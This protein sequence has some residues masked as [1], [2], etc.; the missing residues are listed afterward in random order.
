[1]RVLRS[2]RKSLAPVAL[3]TFAIAA[4]ASCGGGGTST[5]RSA[6][7][8]GGGSDATADGTSSAPPGDGS[9]PQ[10]SFS[11]DSGA[12]DANDSS[13]SADSNGDGPGSQPG[14]AGEDDSATALDA[15]GDS[16]SGAADGSPS[17]DAQNGAD[18]EAGLCSVDG[19]ACSLDG[20][21]GL[22]GAGACGSCSDPSSDSVCSGAYGDGG[23]GGY[24]CT[25]GSCVPGNCHTDADCNGGICGFVTA[26]FCAGCTADS[27]CQSD[28]TYGPSTIC[29][30]SSKKCVTSAC[31]TVAAA[32]SNAGDICCPGVSGNACVPGN[33]CSDAQCSG[34]T[35]VCNTSTNACAV[36]DAV[37]AGATYVIVDPVNGKDIASNGSGTVGSG[38]VEDG[39]CA[40]KTITFALGHLP[41]GPDGGASVVD[42]VRVLPTG[43]VATGE[44]FPITVPAGMTIEGVGGP[45][46]VNETATGDGTFTGVAF[47]LS[48]AGSTLSNLIIDGATTGVRGVR[49]TTGSTLTTNLVNVEVR[50]FTAAGIRVELSGKLTI[51]S[52]TSAHN[53]GSAGTEPCGLR[54][55]GQAQVTITGGAVPIQFNQNTQN[56]I[57]VDGAGSV[58]ITGTPSGTTGSVVANANLVDGIDIHQTVATAS[59]ITGLVAMGNAED[60]ARFYGPSSVQVR[61]SIFL[62][63][64]NNGVN[65][66]PEGAGANENDVAAI[67]LGTA[68]SAGGNTFQS[69]T[70]PNAFAGICL[71]I[72]T[73]A[74]QTLQAQGNIWGAGDGGAL[75]C[76]AAGTLTE[77]TGKGCSGG[78]DIGGS[79]LSATV[80]AT[81]NGVDVASCS[82]GGNTTCK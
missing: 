39:A 6:S 35:P 20:G 61:G 49:A 24:I 58:T 60:G 68:V 40:F 8:D 51:N 33:C 19:T 42:D 54:V 28:V 27:Q 81:S 31:T 14:E 43:P 45:V 15:G 32:C 13:S 9:A 7:E 66:L 76:G 80:T 77:N 59:T 67:D 47:T 71:N 52:G 74:S 2:F 26:Q 5:T 30:T 46:T 48:A 53:N 3:A 11:Q 4:V 69:A 22:C 34:T 78:V 21:N 29:D 65:V 38:A 44:D 37:G 82:C 12:G 57:L 79:G 1:M 55:T 50:N 73:G 41:A 10:D 18:S 16:E 75:N 56:G 72:G 64:T 17:S 36:C 70:T 23:A 25:A 63:N 62:G